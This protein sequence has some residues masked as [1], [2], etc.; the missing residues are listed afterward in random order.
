MSELEII[1][2]DPSAIVMLL[3]L[4]FVCVGIVI[5]N[6]DWINGKMT[7]ERMG[8]WRRNIL[9]FAIMTLSID[10]LLALILGL[11]FFYLKSNY[12]AAILT[13]IGALAISIAFS[14][15]MSYLKHLREE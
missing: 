6:K 4:I 14:T 12:I 7:H 1:F 10:G 11:Y 15:T 9:Q 8:G 2:A 5:R 3:T 13:A